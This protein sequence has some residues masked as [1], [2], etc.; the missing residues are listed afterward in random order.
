MRVSQPQVPA[1]R[2]D[3]DVE[4]RR[5]RVVAEGQGGRVDDLPVGEAILQ[6][7]DVG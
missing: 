3:K 1:A 4:R 5:R 6:R 7:D 2:V